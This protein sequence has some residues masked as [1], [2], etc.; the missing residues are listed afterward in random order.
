MKQCSF[1]MVSSI[2]NIVFVDDIQ[3]LNT[4]LILWW[5]YDI[6]VYTIFYGLRAGF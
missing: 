1:S 3:R 6:V 4:C 2:Y 5:V